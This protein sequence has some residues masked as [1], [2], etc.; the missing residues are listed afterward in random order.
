VNTLQQ[1]QNIASY[2]FLH[3]KLEKDDVHLHAF[4]F[5]VYTGDF[6]MFSRERKRFVLVS[7]ETYQHLVTDGVARQN[8]Q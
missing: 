5:D 3:E 4:W 1:L 8:E 7:E 6:H 2:P